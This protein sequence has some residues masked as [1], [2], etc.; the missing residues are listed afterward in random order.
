[1]LHDVNVMEW[2]FTYPEAR[3]QLINWE[4]DWAMPM[5]AQLRLHAERWPAD[6]RMKIVID[7]IFADSTA[8][9][10]WNSPKLPTLSHPPAAATRKLYLPRRGAKEFEVSL[11]TMKVD[12]LSS[13]RLM[14]VR[15]LGVAQ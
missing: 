13:C 4:S 1:M 6:Q 5:M 12:E 8:K 7:A 14:T 9:A 11:L 2:V 10:L 3:T 15:P